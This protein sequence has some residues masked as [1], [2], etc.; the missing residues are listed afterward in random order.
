L[1]TDFTLEDSFNTIGQQQ[2]LGI[3]E[4]YFSCPIPDL[5]HLARF[6]L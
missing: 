3:P 4:H 2:T 5:S 1:K 6:R